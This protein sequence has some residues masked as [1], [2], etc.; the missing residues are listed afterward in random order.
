MYLTQKIQKDKVYITILEFDVTKLFCYSVLGYD[1]TR[2]RVTMLVVYN[3]TIRPYQ[4][5]TT[6]ALAP[7]DNVA[8]TFD[9]TWS[10]VMSTLAYVAIRFQIMMLLSYDATRWPYQAT[11]P[12]YCGVTTFDTIKCQVMIM[13]CV[14]ET[15]HINKLKKSNDSLIL[16]NNSS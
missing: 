4:V 6:L 14:F 16:G 13:T 7:L 9:T 10:K 2:F 12:L 1:V 5:M 11:T 15:I 8:S 3:A